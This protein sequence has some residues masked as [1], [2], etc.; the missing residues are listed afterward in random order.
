VVE[1][2]GFGRT[3]HYLSARIDGALAGAP[4][5]AVVTAR[6]Q[7]SDAETLRVAAAA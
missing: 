1:K 2:P 4:A 7:A 3:A 6:T 5:G